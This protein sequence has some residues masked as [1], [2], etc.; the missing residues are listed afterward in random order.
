MLTQ[1]KTFRN[2][3]LELDVEADSLAKMHE[4]DAAWKQEAYEMAWAFQKE[5]AHLKDHP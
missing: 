2:A 3:S 5:I 1:T 4:L